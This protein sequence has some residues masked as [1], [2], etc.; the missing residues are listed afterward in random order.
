VSVEIS[1]VNRNIVRS[2]WE[3]TNH[4]GNLIDIDD[5]QQLD[6]ERLEQLM[7][8]CGGF[9]LVVGGSPCNNGWKQQG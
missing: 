3:H 5:V 7:S 8:S 9:D 6:A 4:K 1:E 2:W